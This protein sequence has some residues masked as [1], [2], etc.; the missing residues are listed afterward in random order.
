MRANRVLCGV[1]FWLAACS[2]E[3]GV[4]D[5][6]AALGT[7]DARPI[8]ASVEHKADASKDSQSRLGV[9]VISPFLL[10]AGNRADPSYVD[11]LEGP[12]ELDGISNWY[13]SQS[14]AEW[15]ADFWSRLADHMNAA[16]Y[17]PLVGSVA[18]GNPKLDADG[19][20]R[21]RP[22]ATMIRS[23]N[24]PIG[25]S[26]HAYSGVLSTDLSVEEWCT[27]RYRKII[28]E[29]QLQGV[30]LV[31]TEGG[32]DVCPAGTPGGWKESAV[33]AQ[34]Y[35]DW[36]RWFD[37][38]LKKDTDVVGVTLFQIGNTGDWDAFD[39]GPL[40]E[41]LEAYIVSSK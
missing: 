25:W 17:T 5:G 15:F 19:G 37:E 23:K 13:E 9:H 22:L 21:M 7:V 1:G 12:N 10:N 24:Y 2:A 3:S 41:E 38:E 6:D 35:F 34:G 39:L 31:L 27:F 36:L 18:V 14:E 8:D 16:G 30:P 28:E 40:A 32:Q 29:T 26:Y 11:W 20:N 4:V 33:D